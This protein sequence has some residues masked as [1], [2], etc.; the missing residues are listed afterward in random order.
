ML[1]FCAVLVNL[2]GLMYASIDG[3]SFSGGQ[4]GITYVIILVIA[5]SVTYLILALITDVRL[6]CKARA[7]KSAEKSAEQRAETR[8]KSKKEAMTAADVKKVAYET[9]ARGRRQSTKLA[10]NPMFVSAPTPTGAGGA[11]A[12]GEGGDAAALARADILGRAEAP[13]GA[14]WNAFKQQFSDLMEESTTTSKELGNTRMQLRRVMEALNV[15]SVEDLMAALS[16]LGASAA[17]RPTKAAGRTRTAYKPMLSA[18]EPGSETA[19]TAAATFG[20]G[21]GAGAS[22]ASLAGYSSPAAANR[23][24]AGGRKP[25]AA[26]AGD[27]AGVE[28]S[29]MDGGSGADSTPRA[30]RPSRVS[31]V[32]RVS[33]ALGLGLGSASREPLAAQTDAGSAGGDSPT[34]AGRASPS[35][36]RTSV[37]AAAVAAAAAAAGRGADF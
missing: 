2:M 26:A 18:D 28:L 9:A 12:G 34:S 1:L 5:F 4:K 27:G 17:G 33:N 30:R 10:M 8:S 16:R 15:T 14:L 35:R 11:G 37:S 20:A 29:P 3:T 25:G 19:S 21:A 6:Q 24:R 23:M 7:A 22:G 13:D 31:V 32:G 36:R